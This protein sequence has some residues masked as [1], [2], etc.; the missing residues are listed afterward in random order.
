MPNVIIKLY[1]YTLT[2]IFQPKCKAF[3]MFIV[4]RP[5]GTEQNMPQLCVQHNYI[6]WHN[7]Y[8]TSLVA[9]SPQSNLYK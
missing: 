6:L 5:S 7:K 3:D 8:C 9:V 1:I 2:F 4:T